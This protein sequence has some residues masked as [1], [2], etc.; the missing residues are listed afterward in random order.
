[1]ASEQS[2]WRQD[3]DRRM[4]ER[5]ELQQRLH[6]EDPE[7]HSLLIPVDDEDFPTEAY[8]AGWSQEP[9]S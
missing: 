2:Q 6:A 8:T 7:R 4:R 5:D 1:M 3:F 9:G